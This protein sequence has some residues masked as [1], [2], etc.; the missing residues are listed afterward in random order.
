MD[1]VTGAVAI[2]GALRLAN[3]KWLDDWFAAAAVRTEDR[4]QHG[5][6]ARRRV[7]GLEAATGLEPA[8]GQPA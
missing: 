5:P 3:A 1:L 4:R 6:R 8:T 7:S 2:V